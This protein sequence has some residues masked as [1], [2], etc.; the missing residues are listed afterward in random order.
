M[1]FR[2]DRRAAGAALALASGL[3]GAQTGATL[4]AVTITGNPLGRD[5]LLTPASRLS[6]DD[7]RLRRQPSLGETLGTQ[8]G[9]ASTYYGPQAS[10][11][12]IRGLDGDRIRILSN[13]TALQDASGLSYDHAVSA[14]PLAAEA[15]EVLRGPGALLHGGTAIGG[16]VN[17]LDNRIPREPVPGVTGRA[18]ASYA[19]GARERAGAALLE[20][21]GPRA[22]LHVDVFDRDSGDA[23]VP[24]SLA[25]GRGG[26][27]VVRSRLCNADSRSR[28]GAA[29]GTLFFDRGY[30]GASVQETRNAYGAVAEE[31]VRIDMVSRRAAIDG[32]WRPVQSVWQSVRLQA[33]H[34]DYRHA[35]IEGGATGTVFQLRGDEFRLQARHARVGPLEGVIGLQADSSRFSA[36]G[37][38]AFAPPSRT[39]QQAL[40]VYEEVGQPWGRVSFGARAEQVRVRTAGDPAQARFA[41]GERRFTPG[42]VALGALWKLPAGWQLTGNLARSERAPTHYELFADGPHVAT[43]AYEV[44]NRQLGTERATQVDAGLQWRQQDHQVTLTAFA[45][46]F[47][48]YIALLPTGAEQDLEGEAL[49]VYAYTAVPARLQGLEA[50]ARLRL[51]DAPVR[52]NLET[53]ADTVRAWRTDTGE[54]LPRMAPMR[55]G[56]TLV[57]SQGP[58]SAR[59]GF[60][61]SARQDRVPQGERAT[62]AATLWH[63]SFD[64]RMQAGT[65]QWLWFIRGEN[66]GNRLAYSATSIL[67]QTAPGRVPLPGRSVKVG[68]QATY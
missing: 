3:A 23:R 31:D 39:R 6:G 28:G 32:E 43:G 59:V 63:A 54:P 16:V 25:C 62:D 68:L 40:F 19:T 57:A 47:G 52:I 51:R 1:F 49:P 4:P 55:V 29:G 7:L 26:V 12:V 44:G 17:V 34:T 11:P 24:L 46:R 27:T 33:A 56:A 53:R 38:E 65:V 64:W 37:E 66:L 18:E 10:R 30:L 41:P 22:A 8:P 36:D 45:S 5:D 67:T 61:H 21:G 14:D 60:D 20:A 15:V 50:T 9:I 48:N 35:E 2:I 42:S 13:G 58:W